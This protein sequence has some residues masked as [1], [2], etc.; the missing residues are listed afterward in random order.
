MTTLAQGGPASYQQA[1]VHRTVR[2]MTGGAIL[3]HRFVLPKHGAAL[4]LV[5]AVAVIVQRYL[6][7]VCIGS[8][9]M[10]V[11]TIRARGFTLCYRVS[12]R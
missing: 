3:S 9:A 4:F 7:E 10:W 2:P 8:A 6:M 11:V 1:I 5:A 12:G